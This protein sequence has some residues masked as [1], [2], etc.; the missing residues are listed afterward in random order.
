MKR[1]V[2]RSSTGNDEWNLAA[3][4]WQ[5]SYGKLEF[6]PTDI[7]LN[8][9]SNVVVTV[10]IV[11]DIE[12]DA[13]DKTLLINIKDNAMSKLN[14]MYND[15]IVDRVDEILFCISPIDTW[16]TGSGSFRAEL[17]A[18]GLYMMMMRVFHHLTKCMKSDIISI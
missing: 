2:C 16:K 18:I 7:D 1:S 15:K 9:I 12:I 4:F 10:V 11:N 3:G 13:V 5:C 8:E 17:V 14:E 6:I